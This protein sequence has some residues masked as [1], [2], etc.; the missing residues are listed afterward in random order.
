MP[1]YEIRSNKHFT[2]EDGAAIYQSVFAFADNETIAKEM[3]IHKFKEN[4]EERFE[5]LLGMVTYDLFDKLPEAELKDHYEA[6]APLEALHAGARGQVEVIT[7]A[8]CTE[9]VSVWGF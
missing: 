2:A 7:H 1:L 6:D 5:D 4:I 3:G 9:V 8:M